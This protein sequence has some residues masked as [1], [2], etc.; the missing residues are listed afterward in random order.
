MNNKVIFRIIGFGVLTIMTIMGLQAFW[1]IKSYNTNYQ[2]FTEKSYYALNKVAR[3][4]EKIGSPL[5]D[6]DI[7]KQPSSNYFVVNVN[8]VI[9]AN[10]LKHFLLREFTEVGLNEEFEYGIYDCATNQMIYHDI[11]TLNPNSE[12]PI[13]E[14]DP[15]LIYDEY[16]YYFGVRFPN[17]SFEILTSMSASIILSGILLVTIFFFLFSMRVILKQKKLSELQK[18]FINNM[19]HE[20]KTPISTS[21]IAAQVFLDSTIVRGDTR[22]N[23][24]AHIL[25][26]QINRLNDQVERVLEIAKVGQKGMQLNKE[27][28]DLKPFLTEIVNNVKEEINTLNGSIDIEFPEEY[29]SINADPVHL[30]NTINGLIDNAKKYYLNQP[31]ITVKLKNEGQFT[32]L[33]VI[34]KGPGIPKEHQANIFDKFFRIPTGNVHDVKGFGLGLFYIKSVCK[35]HNWT[36]RLK[37]ELNQGTDFTIKMK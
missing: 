36:I 18:D 23:Q 16:T 28:V 11:L 30:K 22:L 34:D 9:N 26:S 35:Q 20:F 8:D 25:K 7:I 1:L 21:G 2:E 3:E 13:R 5:P 19:T 10:N 12:L 31:E 15:L 6:Y 17:R 37:S 29:L 27:N 33:S 32:T 4:F 24:Y 14:D